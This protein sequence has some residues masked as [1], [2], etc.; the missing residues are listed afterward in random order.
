MC[1]KK[2]VD[3]DVTTYPLQ[4]FYQTDRQTDSGGPQNITPSPSE[5]MKNHRLHVT[6]RI[7]VVSL[8]FCP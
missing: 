1:I 3:Q 6:E 8:W 2:L 5:L 7:P 4:A